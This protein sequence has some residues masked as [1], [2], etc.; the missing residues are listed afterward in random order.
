MYCRNCGTKQG[1][2]EKFCPMCG[3]PFMMKKG[4]SE[5]KMEIGDVTYKRQTNP[6]EQSQKTQL[7][8][9]SMR[10]MGFISKKKKR[11]VQ[12]VMSCIGLILFGV[13]GLWVFIFLNGDIELLLGSAFLVLLGGGW[14]WFEFYSKF[15][16][17]PIKI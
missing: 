17:C 2:G 11:T 1:E 3:T 14:L 13:V 6:K 9:L 10:K 4:G 5:R 15:H 16:C 7:K 12:T 8:V